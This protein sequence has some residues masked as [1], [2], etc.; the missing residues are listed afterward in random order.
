MNKFISKF[1]SGE[2]RHNVAL[3]GYD[4]NRFQPLEAFRQIDLC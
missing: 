4:Y 1:C 3:K 2:D